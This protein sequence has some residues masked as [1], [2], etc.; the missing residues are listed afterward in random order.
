MA[1]SVTDYTSYCFIHA[2]LARRYTKR[3]GPVTGPLPPKF[4]LYGTRR[5]VATGPPDVIGGK[6]EIE[7][8]SE[9]ED[10]QTVSAPRL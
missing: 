10:Q 7:V 2:K 6:I 9:L 3:E 1:G 5:I 4:D 8:G